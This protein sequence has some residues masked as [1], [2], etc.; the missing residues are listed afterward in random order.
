[1]IKIEF[2]E[3]S[4]NCGGQIDLNDVYNITQITSPSYPNIPP[5]HI[6]CIWRVVAPSGERISVNIE[7]L[8]LSGG[9]E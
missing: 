8:D 4:I 1:V 3:N 5:P 6:E 9:D 7:D 2:E